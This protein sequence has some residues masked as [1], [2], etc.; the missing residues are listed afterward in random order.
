MTEST[1]AVSVVVT[2]RNEVADIATCLTSVRAQTV[3]T[4][5]VVVDNGSSDGTVEIAR[6]L[7]DVVIEAGP[8]RSAQRNAGA[9]VASGESLLFLDADMELPPSVVERCLAEAR[10]GAAAVVIPERSVGSGTWARAKALERSC[11]VGDA[12][13]EAARFFSR[14]VFARHGG[15]DE[16]LTGPEDWDLPARIRA[17]ERIARIDVQIVHHEGRI[18]LRD[19]VRKKFYYGRSFRTYVRKHPA[20]ARRQL[21]LV[22]PAFVRNWRTLLR[23]PALTSLMIV[24]KLAEFAGGAAGAVAGPRR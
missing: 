8:E 10:R 9:R 3:A 20:L 21:V 2:T 23:H 24:M 1:P 11:Y 6:R 16:A 17:A 14:E 15:Y 18:T 12:T 5:I 4:E 7:A 22:R 13:I 19:L